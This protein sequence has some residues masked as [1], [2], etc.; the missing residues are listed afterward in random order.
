[1]FLLIEVPLQVETKADH[2]GL[3]EKPLLLFSSYLLLSSLALSD[4]SK[5]DYE[6]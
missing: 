6:P 4:R 1:M 2:P 5:K 3:L